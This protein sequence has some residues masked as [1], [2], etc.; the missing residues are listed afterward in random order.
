LIK[1]G[2][3]MD[4]QKIALWYEE[5]KSCRE[6]AAYYNVTSQC[7][8]KRLRQ[9]NATTRKI[10]GYYTPEELKEIRARIFQLRS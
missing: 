8:S 6:I 7:I 5:G 3:K 4:N 1:S 9:L 2:A 10:A